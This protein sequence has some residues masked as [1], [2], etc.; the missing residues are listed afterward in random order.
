MPVPPR[1]IAAIGVLLAW[2]ASLAWLGLR[3]GSRTESA[4]LRS[5]ASLRLSPGDVWFAVMAGDQQLGLA[6]VTL[7]TLGSAYRVRETVTLELP[8]DSATYRAN[9]TTDYLMGPAL[10]VQSVESRDGLHGFRR[11]A[12]LVSADGG[13]TEV[14]RHEDRQVA[15]GRLDGG[16]PIAVLLAPYRLALTGALGTGESRRL[17]TLDGWPAAAGETSYTM[18]ADTV[19]VFADSAIVRDPGIGWEVAHRDSVTA[20]TV[21]VE[22]PGGPRLMW[23]DRRGTLTG[24]AYP[25]GVRWVRTDFMLANAPFTPGGATD[26]ST[27]PRA[28]LP[29]IRPWAGSAVARQPAD[30]VVSYAVT[31]PDGSAIPRRW[32]QLYVGSGVEYRARAGSGRGVAHQLRVATRAAGRQP[33]PMDTVADPLIQA[34]D[35][36]VR[37]LADSMRGPEGLDLELVRARFARI[38]VDTSAEAPVDAAGTLRGGRGHPDGV[39]R[40]LAALLRA[41]GEQARYVIGVASVADTLYA[42]AWVE[43]WEPRRRRWQA[44]DPLTMDPASAALLRLAAAGSSHPEDI[45]PMVADVRLTRMVPDSADAS[46]GTDR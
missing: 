7:D 29:T 2:G 26:R 44:I 43:R 19:V 33:I 23:V 11:L 35:E 3:S 17:Q 46:E 8:R 9:R 34:A 30:S 36:M 14:V 39:A 25:F 31:R 40:L 45:L 32:I 18:G 5:E 1:N 42:H 12:R 38:A 41:S 24:M 4:L 21:V 22:G 15:D 6:G 20:H 10:G 27:S 28:T 16:I 37:A 13:W